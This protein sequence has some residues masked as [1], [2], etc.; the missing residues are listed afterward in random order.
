MDTT[1]VKAQLGTVV[2][3][4]RY[5]RALANSMFPYSLLRVASLEGIES[6][7]VITEK[8]ELSMM[9]VGIRRNW[10]GNLR[11]ALSKSCLDAAAADKI[12]IQAGTVDS[13]KGSWPRIHHVELICS[14]VGVE[15]GSSDDKS[16]MN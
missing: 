14:N 8:L 2:S 9:V 4:A 5:S 3:T 11:L 12:Q 6:Y 13:H 7:L 1:S 16:L 10:V 15:A